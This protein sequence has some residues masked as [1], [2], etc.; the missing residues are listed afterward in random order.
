MSNWMNYYDVSPTGVVRSLDRDY[1]D[2]MGRCRRVKSH[3]L[4]TFRDKYGYEKVTLSINRRQVST[5][6]GRLVAEKYLPNPENLPHVNHKNENKLDNRAENLEW[7]TVKYNQNYG[8]RNE[9]M[10]RSKDKPV[11]CVYPDGSE[12]SFRSIKDASDSLSINRES[13][14]QC[15]HGKLRRTSGY[16]FRFDTDKGV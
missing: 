6:V 1:V 2:S 16:M 15:A 3:E 9:R 12:T 7:C 5:T 11:I 13:I 4:A 8:T 14:S 10:A